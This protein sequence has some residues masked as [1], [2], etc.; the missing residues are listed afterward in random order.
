M[1]LGRRAVLGTG[2]LLLAGLALPAWPSAGADLVEVALRSDPEGGRVRFDP[3]GLLVAPGTRVRWINRENV[4]TV[5]AYHPANDNRS[6]R[7][8]E[9]AEPWDSGYL[10]EPGDSF[11]LR[12]VQPGVYD[13][14]CRPHEEAGMVG[15]II[16][17]TATGPGA[18][19]FDY[20]K[21]LTPAPAWREV[22]PLARETFPPIARILEEG[23]VAA[24][25]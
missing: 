25:G 1:S 21:A 3:V 17:G 13:Y 24:G 2:G 11:E 12:L 20:F 22:P 5:T 6:L 18:L 4:H 7:I 15:R 9:D 8:P 19:P 14:F 23:R 10:V 16:V